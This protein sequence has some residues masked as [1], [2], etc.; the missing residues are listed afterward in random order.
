MVRLGGE[1]KQWAFALLEDDVL[2]RYNARDA[3]S[4][5]R[6]ADVLMG[7]LRD[8]SHT[9]LER[10][11]DKLI[12]PSLYAAEQME[13]WGIAVDRSRVDGYHGLLAA[14]ISDVKRR[15]DQY[16]NFNPSSTRDVARLLYTDLGLVSQEFTETGFPSTA[17][18]A[19][20]LLVDQHP[21]VSDL[22]EWRRLTK[23]MGTY[24]EALPAYIRADGRVHPTFRIDGARSGRWS[25]QDPN[26]Q[27]LPRA[28]DSVEGKMARDC[29]VAGPGRLLVEIDFSQLELRVAASLSG[30]PLMK[31]V[32]T[33]G[34]DY[35]L[36][37]A[38]MVSQQVWGVR[39]DD[40][41]DPMRTQAKTVNFAA[42]Y[43]AG[44]EKIAAML[45]MD[46]DEAAR[47]KRAI[48]GKF[49]TLAAWIRNCLRQVQASGEAWTWWDGEPFRRRPLPYICDKDG[50]KRSQAE[51]AAWN[52]PIQ[53]TASDL[54]A[55]SLVQC[56]NWIRD[57][58]APVKLVATIH[59]ALLFEVDEGFV[60]T[61]IAE[62]TDVMT[63]WPAPGP[64]SVP[65]E[66]DVKVGPSWGSLGKP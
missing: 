16:P 33:S 28:K 62:A 8:G 57:T 64:Q 39:P 32:F 22:L 24:A 56:V 43:G 17:K 53:G 47:L 6:I 50:S 42:L 36:A 44:D 15:F 31:E 41:T 26:L 48:F 5:D 27:N 49:S 58:G 12:L 34:V 66:V 52:S 60:P 23:M 2:H 10:V 45:K 30:D 63:G 7:R 1:P 59:D 20:K 18:E 40:V 55:F 38:R 19:L 14:K 9:S 13:A 51:H 21:V 25:C 4:T 54:C 65:F 3:V 29:Y 37:T 11:W 46:V 35:H 61:L